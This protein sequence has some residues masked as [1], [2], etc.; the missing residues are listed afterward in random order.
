MNL[1]YLFLLNVRL[2][3]RKFKFEEGTYEY[4]HGLHTPKVLIKKIN[5]SYPTSMMEML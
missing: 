5:S 1:K 4:I 3:N 2:S